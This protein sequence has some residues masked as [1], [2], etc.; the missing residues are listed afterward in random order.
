MTQAP[1]FIAYTV[2]SRCGCKALWRQIGVAFPHVK[3]LAV[4]LNALPLGGRVVLLEPNRC[5]AQFFPAAMPGDLATR[6]ALRGERRVWEALRRA[7]LP[8]G[9]RIFYN[10]APKGCRR[11]ADL[12][13]LLAGRGIIAIEVK[14]GLVHYRRDLRQRLA[15]PGRGAKRIEPWQQA[16]RA[17]AH[18]LAALSSIPLPS[19]KRRCWRY[20]RRARMLF[21]SRQRHTYSRLRIW[22]LPCLQRRSPRCF[23]GLMPPTARSSRLPWTTSQR[24]SRGLPT[25]KIP[26][27][28][29]SDR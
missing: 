2:S 28:S 9:T 26:N 20:R 23:P 29:L 16:G 3:G 1:A 4:L 14:G 8:A 15:G 25:R 17:L 18:A 24:L 27:S 22:P 19:R 12:L 7:P 10:R 11:R 6:P 13:I 21:P 5:S